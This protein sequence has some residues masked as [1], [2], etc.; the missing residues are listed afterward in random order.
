MKKGGIPL[1]NRPNSSIAQDLF[2]SDERQVVGVRQHESTNA[3]HETTT[4]LST[5]RPVPYGPHSKPLRSTGVSI[6]ANTS[7]VREPHCPSSSE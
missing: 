4:H 1:N 2:T 7:T 5:P 6:R 3:T